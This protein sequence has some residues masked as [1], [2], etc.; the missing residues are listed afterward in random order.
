MVAS[1]ANS[2]AQAEEDPHPW[3]RGAYKEVPDFLAGTIAVSG[4]FW[5]FSRTPV[6][7]G[8]TPRV[9]EHNE[10]VLGDLLGYS[11]EEIEGMRKENVIGEWDKYDSIPGT[12]LA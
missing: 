10:D 12:P 7:V 1:P 5:H 2:I 9:G 8:S 3:V 4:D 6:V 11:S